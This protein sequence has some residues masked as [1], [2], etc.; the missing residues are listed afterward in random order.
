MKNSNQKS[1]DDQKKTLQLSTEELSFILSPQAIR[2]RARGIFDLT[3]KG[4]GCFT[5]HDEK[6][7]ETVRFVIEEI[8]Q[9]Y[10]SLEI[11]FHS[12]WGH[13]AVGGIARKDLLMKKI[14]GEP[15]LE[16]ARILLDLVITSV[17]LDAGAGST[18]KF[19]EE[20]S[21]S[22]FGRSEGLGVASFYLFLSGFLSSD[23]Q[24]PLQ[25]DTTGLKQLRLQ[26]LE[27]A[28]QVSPKNPLI[29]VEGRL[30]LLNNL[31]SAVSDSK[32]FKDG[33]PGNILDYLLERY[34]K[35]IP[36][37]GI[38]SAVLEGLGSI[39]PG[40]LEARGVN[41]G[42]VW[43]H[44]K[45]GSKGSFESLV[46]FHKLS[47]WMTYSLIEPILEA[48]LQVDGVNSLTGLAE[49]RNGGL[50]ID[51]GL[52]RPRDPKDLDRQWSPD[53]DFIIEWRALTIHL[54]DIIGEK[55][56]KEL[57]QSSEQF[58][59]AKVLEGGT[60][61]AGRKLAAQRA[62]GGSPIQIQSDGTVF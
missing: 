4:E 31:A 14:Q 52:I 61:W 46:P 40:R 60:W 58:P 44:S 10:P 43:S 1:D 38:L 25:A 22:S 47:Q 45:L 7:D 2:Q 3:L 12:R 13:F 39:W 11:P 6:L 20:S 15:P 41:L 9:R 29:G 51:S 50:M 26:T 42:D 49:Y 8:K 21:K 16:R 56:R 23:P 28:F 18:W 54:L 24:K 36:A 55:V 17:L 19:Y 30:L 48:G 35:R 37:Q 59:L 62:G 57:N 53:S 33:R 27:A 34:G 32:R 5:Y